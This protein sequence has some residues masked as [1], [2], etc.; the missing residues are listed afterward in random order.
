[1]ILKKPYAFLIK[2]FKLMHLIIC[3]LLVYIAY[4]CNDM[5]YYFTQYINAGYYI[6]IGDVV[7]DYINIYLYLSL[8]I[9]LFF[10]LTTIILL[11]IKEK[12]TFIYGPVRWL[13]S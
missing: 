9:I 12:N 6:K 3:A 10:I 11:H 4:K 5:L 13:S 2:H 1:M 7:G 8:F